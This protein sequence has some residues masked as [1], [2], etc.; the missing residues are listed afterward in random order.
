[1]SHTILVIDDDE[2]I[3]IMAKSLLGKEFQLVNARDSQE[4]INILSETPVNLI[5]S[6]IHM[7]GLSGLELLESIRDDKE[8]SKIPVLI[9][10]NL[11]TVEKEQKALDLGAVDFI[12]KERF[13]TDREGV[14]ELVRMKILTDVN[15]KGLDEDLEK[16]KNKL[17]MKL[18][19]SAIK[20]SFTDTA[21]T[22]CTYLSDILN[23]D[24]LTFFVLEE[25]NPNPLIVHGDVKPSETD[26]STF[27]NSNS[28]DHL[29]A[30]KESYL[31]NHIYNEEFGCFLDFSTK[32]EMPAEIGVPLFSANEK[33]MLMNNLSAPTEAELFG[34]L[35]IK[36]SKLFSSKEFELISR[37]V[38]QTG[39]ILWR[40][41]QKN[42]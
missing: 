27:Q 14:I 31:S 9:M 1:M 26:F 18:M 33:A 16:S 38:T 39:A 21:E 17:V 11:P 37:L 35:I 42:K 12:K 19:E 7:P 41:Y 34:M 15:V 4:A 40:L 10:T 28:F 23:S 8:K 20:G 2:P 32:N 13:N 6:D 24:L 30:K 22:F 3:H 29:S 25:G 5:L 36:R